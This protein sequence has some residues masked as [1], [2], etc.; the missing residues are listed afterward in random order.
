MPVG[1]GKFDCINSPVIRERSDSRV[2]T[3][4]DL[5]DQERT[6]SSSN[7]RPHQSKMW[8]HTFLHA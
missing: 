4:L 7:S 5:K 8:S 6:S 1:D 2:Y 3:G